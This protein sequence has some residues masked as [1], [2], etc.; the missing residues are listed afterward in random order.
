MKLTV[1]SSPCFSTGEIRVI[2]GS[3]LEVQ[4][5]YDLRMIP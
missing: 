4:K 3:L 1:Y 5:L 2:R